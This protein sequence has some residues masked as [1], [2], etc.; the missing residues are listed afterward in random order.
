[1]VVGGAGGGG[2][3][4]TTAGLIDGVFF[5]RWCEEGLLGH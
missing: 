4:F 5:V 2:V 1:L 3:R